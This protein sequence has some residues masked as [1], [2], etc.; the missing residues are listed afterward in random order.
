MFRSVARAQRTDRQAPAIGTVTGF[1]AKNGRVVPGPASDQLHVNRVKRDAN[2]DRGAAA[3]SRIENWEIKA[4]KRQP[5][6]HDGECRGRRR[7]HARLSSRRVRSRGRCHQSSGEQRRSDRLGDADIG[8]PE[9][10]GLENNI[11][12]ASGTS[13]KPTVPISPSRASRSDVE[14][15]IVDPRFRNFR[16]RPRCGRA[17]AIADPRSSIV[18]ARKLDS[19]AMQ[20]RT[21][22]SSCDS[23]AAQ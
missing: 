2:E 12:R 16:S 17:R 21:R 4:L 8:G 22:W 10:A 9:G 20:S 18:S 19:R 13:G 14:T 1:L 7:S 6:A 11:V 5:F 3:G 23:H 15:I